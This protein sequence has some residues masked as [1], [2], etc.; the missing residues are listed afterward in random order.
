MRPSDLA[1]YSRSWTDEQWWDL[2]FV[3]NPQDNFK[4]IVGGGHN[5]THPLGAPHTAADTAEF[6]NQK[7]RFKRRAKLI[8]R[9]YLANGGQ[10]TGFT[11][12]DV[13]DIVDSLRFPKMS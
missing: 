12:N 4:I 2:W 1:I 8:R 9:Q 10:F 5:A 11:F 13:E 7:S 6:L 3:V